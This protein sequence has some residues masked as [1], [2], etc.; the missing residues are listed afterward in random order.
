MNAGLRVAGTAEYAGLEAA[1]DWRRAELLKAQA[2]R[3][4]AGVRLDKVP[5][6]S[7]NRPSLPDGLPVLGKRNRQ[8]FLHRGDCGLSQRTSACYR[9]RA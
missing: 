6:W 4:F 2:Q 5:R 9:P 7:G 3:M 8:P 1:P